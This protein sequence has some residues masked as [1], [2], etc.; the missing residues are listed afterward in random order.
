MRLAPAMLT[1]LLLPLAGCL[2]I[3]DDAGGDEAAAPTS[4]L[5]D[6]ALALWD[7]GAPAANINLVGEWRNGGGAEIDAW[8]N[9][10]FVDR[11]SA[12]HILDVTDPARP[13]EVSVVDLAPGV[14]DVKVSDDGNW[15][16]IGEDAEGSTALAGPVNDAVAATPVGGG[17]F[18]GGFY[19]IDIS[20]K[21]NPTYVSE[22]LVGP[23]RGPHMVFYHQQADGTELVLGANADV[24][25]NRFDRD[26]GTLTELS[27]YSPDLIFDFNR[28]PEVFDVL[29]QGWA[30]DMFV[31]EDPVDNATLMYVANWDAG[32]RIVDLTDPASPVE[33][34]GWN[35]FP[36]GHEGNLHTVATDWVGDRRITIGTVEVGFAVV[37]GYHYAMGT[38]RSILYVWDTTDPANIELLGTWENPDKEPAGRDYVPDEEI[39]STHNFQFEDGR[40]YLAHY[41]LG[42]WVLDVSTPENQADPKV[43]GY[44]LEE[45]QNT[46]DVLIQRGVTW[47]SGVEGVLGLHFITDEVGVGGLNGRA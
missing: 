40:I 38:D 15:M 43:L 24:S 17:P 3:G 20:D 28:D 36:E 37:G 19:V 29:Y 41:G 8:E 2:D 5:L 26:A 44:Y 18:T 10:L 9:Y 35:A 13:E 33:V 7:S 21:E 34:G 27:R 30:H 31:M 6:D 4:A 11:G 45:G 47:T 1:L 25:I 16:F 32:L 23:R 22:L 46:W 42:V 12:V 14:L 39:T